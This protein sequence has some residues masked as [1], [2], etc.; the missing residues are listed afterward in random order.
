MVHLTQQVAATVDNAPLPAVLSCN[1]EQLDRAIKDVSLPKTGH[2][3][4]SVAIASLAAVVLLSLTAFGLWTWMRAGM[5][6]SN[7]HG[8]MVSGALGAVVSAML[9]LVA[10]GV[11]Q[12]SLL[13]QSVAAILF[14]GA[15]QT[16]SNGD[17]R[18]EVD[19][20][21]VHRIMSRLQA[22]GQSG[23]ASVGLTLGAF[24]CVA[25]G[26]FVAW[27]QWPGLTLFVAS[28]M[29]AGISMASV[30]L[31]IIGASLFGLGAMIAGNASEI[32]IRM[33]VALA[34]L[35]GL[36]EQSALPLTSA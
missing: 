12:P 8:F 25:A 17:G 36:S 31:A 20:R 14:N 2:P 26:A 22:L 32:R 27:T 16:A 10:A 34:R 13:T 30:I 28:P 23:F 6:L 3:A 18:I 15:T 11:Y 24:A 35:R 5:S 33:A 9:G 4:A 29:L 7:A 21:K 1:H 19:V